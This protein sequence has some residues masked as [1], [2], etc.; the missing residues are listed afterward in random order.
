[1]KGILSVTHRPVPIFSFPDEYIINK[2]GET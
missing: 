2:E 1:L